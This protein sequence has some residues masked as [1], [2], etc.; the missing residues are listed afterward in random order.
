MHIVNNR[1]NPKLWNKGRSVEERLMFVSQRN[2]MLPKQASPFYL[3]KRQDSQIKNQ[4]RLLP[5]PTKL[6]RE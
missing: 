3:S 5:W 1:E 4:S 2:E 6:T